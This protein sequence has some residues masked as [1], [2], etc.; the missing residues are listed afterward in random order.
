MTFG[1]S[2]TTVFRKYAD[3]TGV[4]SRAEFWWFVLF[5]TLVSSALG[6][7]NLWTPD[8]VVAVGSS[9]A[10]IWSIGVLL[11]SLAVA[12]RRLRDAGRQWTELFWLLLPIA[13]LIVLIVRLAEPSRTAALTTAV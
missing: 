11:P 1:E 13:G 9:L 8:G 6:S 4:A 10:S 12:V 7:F 2:I 3:F 5:T